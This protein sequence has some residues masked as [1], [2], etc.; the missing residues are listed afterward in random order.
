MAWD[1][2]HGNGL[3]ETIERAGIY[4]LTV[5]TTLT[6][7]EKQRLLDNGIVICSQLLDNL[8][9]LDEINLPRKKSTALVK[10]LNDILHL[11]K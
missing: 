10:E 11:G 8:D 5:L 9:A 3:K 4:P 7:K 6:V 1:Y 2:P